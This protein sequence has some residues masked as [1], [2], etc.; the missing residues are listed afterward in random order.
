MLQKKQMLFV[1]SANEKKNNN[2]FIC[3]QNTENS[4]RKTRKRER[5]KPKKNY[6]ERVRERVVL[7]IGMKRKYPTYRVFNIVFSSIMS[8]ACSI[9]T[10]HF[11]CDLPHCHL[12][13]ICLYVDSSSV[14][15]LFF[16]W[17]MKSRKK[18]FIFDS[19]KIQLQT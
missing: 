5:K 10:T 19:I 7:N 13:Q 3:F 16:I 9:H 1:P 11:I 8:S 17:A 4:Q 15:C 6:P 2:E 14:E 18:S 12:W